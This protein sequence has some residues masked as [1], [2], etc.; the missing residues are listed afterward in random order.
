LTNKIF[1]ASRNRGKIREIENSLTGL[2]ISFSSLLDISDIQ[3][4]K[5]TG[6]TF[7][8]N[9]L[10]KAQ[11][12]Y[13]KVRIPVLADDSGL[14]ADY[15]KGEPGVL[16]ARYA[17]EVT[18][19]L[20]NCRKLLKKFHGVSSSDRKA[21]FRCILVFLDENVPKYFEGVCNGTIIEEMRGVNGFGYDPLF[22]PD[23]FS[24]TFAELDL[25]TKNK[26]SHRGIALQKLKNFLIAK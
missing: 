1:I 9:A 11:A 19:D 24:K 22:V 3:D 6:K 13:N 10:I 17:G 20:K 2:N 21:R 25:E 7:E 18:D 12:S 16:S 23:G 14:E 26:I 8:E 5:E 4:I 15:L